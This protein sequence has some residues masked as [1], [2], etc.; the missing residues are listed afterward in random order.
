MKR[1]HTIPLFLW[2]AL[3]VCVH[4]I[5]GGGAEEV[6]DRISEHLDVRDLAAM[7]RGLARQKAPPIEVELEEAPP[8]DA[9]PAEPDEPDASSEPKP[10]E[11]APKP[12]AKE[13]K[14]KEPEKPK[15]EAKKPEVQKPK[16]APKPTA[17]PLLET[18]PPEPP[19]PLAP[20][21]RI[22]VKQHL[23]NENQEDNPNARFSAD[24]ANR[25]EKET[26]ARITSNDQNAKVPDPGQGK[27]T[28]PDD[29][30]NSEKSRVAS[31]VEEKG[32][33]IAPP[34]SSAAEAASAEARERAVAAQAA[35]E[36]AKATPAAAPPTPEQQAA[37]ERASQTE[38]LAGESG[39]DMGP[40]KGSNA[41]RASPKVLPSKKPPRPTDLL[42]FGSEARTARGINLN[43]SPVIASSI[44]GADSLSRDERRRAER[45]LSQHRGAFQNLG[46]ERWR[47]SIENYVAT[48]QPG[49]Q[50]ALNTARIPFA[51]YLH[52]IHNRI[53]PIFAEAFLG[54]LASLPPNHPLNNMGMSTHIEVA[55]SAKD[56]HIVK[57]GVT[58]S[59]SVTMFDVG[60]L[61]SVKR[62]S[63]FGP[64]PGAIV[65]SDGNVYLH[66]EFHRR[67]ELACSTYFAR[68]FLLNVNGGKEG[69]PSAPPAG[70]GEKHGS[71][72]P[73]GSP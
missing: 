34:P 43:L 1:E 44:I 5:F 57:M 29:P 8:P 64:P 60:A 25:V 69:A 11:A 2:V 14:A 21:N 38:I 72:A 61:D 6:S 18:K 58:K 26:Q 28:K 32:E 66:W 12:Q 50:T 65:S 56:G 37:A 71:L 16:E 36:K 17:K 47:A 23:D 63:P 62:A 42:G 73:A 45:R 55:L 4:A 15:P 9:S 70:N 48:V 33:Q 68:P 24:Q 7:A 53:H 46:I 51:T 67:E 54:H 40:T 59:S 3:A 35:A 20:D 22:A 19:P 49:N 10:D 13:P 30:G 27:P 52:D 41:S 31:S 39:P